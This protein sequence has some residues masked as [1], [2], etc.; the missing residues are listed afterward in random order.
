[1]N[2]PLLAAAVAAAL[3]LSPAVHAASDDEL[4]Q[5]RL[6]LQSLMQRVDRLEAENDTLQAENSQ[7]K[8]QAERVGRQLDMHSSELAR[9][10]DAPAPAAASAGWSDRVKLQGDARY[11]HQRSDDESADAEREEDL[12]RA[13][14]SLHAEVNERITAGIGIATSSAPG[15]PRGGNVQ[16]DGEFS[17]KSLYLDFAY[18]DWNVAGNAHLIGGKMKMPFVRPAHSMFWD[19][20]INPEGLAVTYGIGSS[21]ASAWS[22]WV[23][24]NV[25][26]G[27]NATSD[28]TRMYGLQLGHRAHVGRDD[29]TI[30]ASYY[31]LS[32]AKGRRPF[33]NGNA[34]GNSL[35]PAGDLAYDFQ[36]VGL[37]A[38]YDTSLGHAP[39]QVWADVAK[40]LDARY[41]TA[42]AMGMVVGKASSPGTWETGLSYQLIEKDAFF[43]QLIDSDFGGGQSDSRGWVLRTGYAPLPNWVLNATYVKSRRNHDVGTRYDFERL[44][45]D[46]TTRF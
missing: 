29:L 35:T 37:M 5:I 22:F 13:R 20:D 11:R 10:A 6:Q 33:Y 14:I 44:M 17:R 30:A 12:L 26:S 19:S 42:Y 15:N 18:F 16:L 31:D 39:L 24:E 46:F 45:L 4:A 8:R 3:S 21:F 40:N 32:A 27:T 2:N 9:A 43:A 23:E 34:S 36:V 38:E 7:L 41:D 1:V 25:P 28:D